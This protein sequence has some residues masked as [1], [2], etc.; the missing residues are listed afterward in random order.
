MV[1]MGVTCSRLKSVLGICDPSEEAKALGACSS[2][3]SRIRRKAC[4][5]IGPN[6][7][8][9]AVFSSPAETTRGE[10]PLTST[11]AIVLDTNVVLDWM[12]FADPSATTLVSALHQRRVRWLASASMRDELAHVLGRGLARARMA[13]P[14]ALLALWDA[15][16]ERQPEPCAGHRLRC[17]DPDDQKFID[18]ALSSGARWLV[19][20]DRA[21]LKLAR[22]AG[23]LGLTIVAPRHW[24]LGQ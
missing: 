3:R 21:V 19:S 18:L 2:E 22:R 8:P 12:L 16:A 4:D 11:P 15:C 6:P 10:L 1:G 7:Q 13:D 14:D 24:S 9:Q 17:T 20:R 23:A 5:Y